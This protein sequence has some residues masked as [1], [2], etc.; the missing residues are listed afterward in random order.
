MNYQKYMNMKNRIHIFD[1]YGVNLLLIIHRA[2][3]RW[4]YIFE[5][6][7]CSY[8]DSQINIHFIIIITRYI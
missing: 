7:S 6:N 3:D 2:Y 4:V 5:V 8:I 1:M